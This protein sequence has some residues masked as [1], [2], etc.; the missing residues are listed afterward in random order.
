ME[1]LANVETTTGG[2]YPTASVVEV[3][4]VRALAAATAG[5][6]PEVQGRMTPVVGVVV[7]AEGMADRPT[8][9]PVH[10]EG[11]WRDAVA[12]AELAVAHE[13]PAEAAGG[14]LPEEALEVAP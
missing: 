6:G 12:A 11:T 5:H 3:V 2:P 8:D 4:L 10:V 9:G 14:L 13:E 7:E 1:E